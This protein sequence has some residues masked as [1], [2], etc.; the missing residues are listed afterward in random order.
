LSLD[1]YLALLLPLSLEDLLTR[2]LEF[3]RALLLAGV[4]INLL[5]LI[6]IGVSG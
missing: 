5:E 6:L 4:S 3:L 2:S 1:D